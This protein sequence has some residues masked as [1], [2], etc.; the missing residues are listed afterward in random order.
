MDILYILL[1]FIIASLIIRFITDI[2]I[3]TIRE[4]NSKKQFFSNFKQ[5]IVDRK[6]LKELIFFIF[7][8]HFH[9]NSF[10]PYI[11]GF[12]SFFIGYYIEG[13][14]TDINSIFIL[15]LTI[16]LV[17]ATLSL[18]TFTYALVLNNRND[19]V[20]KQEVLDDKYYT[21]YLDK[22]DP[23][24]KERLIKFYVKNKKEN[25]FIH[26]MMIKKSGEIFLMATLLASVGFL[27][28]YAY[29]VLAKLPLESYNSPTITM[30]SV[31]LIIKNPQINSFLIGLYF[32]TASFFIIASIVNFIKALFISTRLL[33]RINRGFT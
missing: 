17:F 5:R 4:S 16:I 27:L 21:N 23:D 6:T 26:E 8:Y 15:T 13:S 3:P 31:F 32:T 12:V 19:N 2:L 28:I 10:M 22:K 7:D 20:F 30:G 9:L 14:S 25:S 29:L 24:L 18:L 1:I 11:V 33:R